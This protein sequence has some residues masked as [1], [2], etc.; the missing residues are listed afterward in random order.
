MNI[1]IDDSDHDVDGDFDNEFVDNTIHQTREILEPQM[2]LVQEYV[3]YFK[4]KHRKK[5]R[6]T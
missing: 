2:D 1:E 3:S 6:L 4:M 5:T